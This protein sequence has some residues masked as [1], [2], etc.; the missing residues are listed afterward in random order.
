MIEFTEIVRS[1]ALNVALLKGDATAQQ[2]LKPQEFTCI[3]ITAF[4]EARGEGSEGMALVVQSMVNRHQIQG[5]SGCRIAQGAYDGYRAWK[6]RDPRL[7]DR[8]NWRRAQLV[9]LNVIM[10]EVDLGNC[11]TLTHFLNPNAVRRMPSWASRENR[12]CRMGNHVGY[13]V[14]RI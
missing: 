13:R 9:A 8:S 5:K 3:A 1:L 10:G 14:A 6:G 4:G 11:S 7:T 12:V 2:L